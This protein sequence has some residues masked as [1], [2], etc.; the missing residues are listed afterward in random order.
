MTQSS[1][2][3]MKNKKQASMRYFKNK[4]KMST[5]KKNTNDK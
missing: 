1:C 4:Q 2:K 5:N 3:A